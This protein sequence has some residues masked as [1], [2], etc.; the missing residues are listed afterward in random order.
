MTAKA[1]IDSLTW[2]EFQKIKTLRDSSP[3]F[4]KFLAEPCKDVVTVAIFAM[5]C[6]SSGIPD[7]YTATADALHYLVVAINAR[8][9][10]NG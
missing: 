10:G 9:C 4:Y 2:E 7:D 1:Y 8:I 5:Q 3:D 6:K